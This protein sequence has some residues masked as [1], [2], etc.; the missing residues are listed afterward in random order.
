MRKKI[1][2]IF[3]LVLLAAGYLFRYELLFCFQY[4]RLKALACQQG[5]ADFINDSCLNKIWAHRVNSK[6]R[7]EKLKGKFAGYETD[8]TWDSSSKK[9]LVYH[10]PLEDTPVSLDTFLQIVSTEK[11]MLWLDTR[12]IPVADT[13]LV[14]SAFDQLD[15]L[16]HLKLSAIIEV[17][18]TTIANFLAEHDYWVSLN[19]N[20]DWIQKF[21]R[22]SQWAQLRNSMSP[23]ISFVSQEDTYVPLLKQHFPGRDII[24]W[25]IAFNNYFNRGHLKELVSDESVKVILVNVKSRYYR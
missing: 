21:S 2:I 12:A 18:D 6:E 10:P 5:D 14:L 11:E 19:I 9:F 22:E 1:I 4:S 3:V 13:S 23:R 15:R 16:H 25:S 20:T 17:Y 7:Y 8:I 24:T